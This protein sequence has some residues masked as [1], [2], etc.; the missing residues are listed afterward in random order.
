MG[1][2]Q[3]SFSSVGRRVIDVRVAQGGSCSGQVLVCGSVLSSWRHRESP[4]VLHV[5]PFYGELTDPE[6]WEEQD[7][8]GHSSD[9]S[10]R[11]FGCFSLCLFLTN[12]KAHS[13]Y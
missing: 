1:S 5:S 11:F 12:A 2:I 8:T 10:T 3:R 9:S 13:P 4:N 6:A 7:V